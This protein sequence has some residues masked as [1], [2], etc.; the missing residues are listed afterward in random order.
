L[1]IFLL[2]GHLRPAKYDFYIPKIQ[3]YTPSALRSFG[4]ISS[5]SAFCSSLAI[6]SSVVFIYQATNDA[7]NVRPVSER[8]STFPK[9][10]ILSVQIQGYIAQLFS[11]E[12]LIGKSLLLYNNTCYYGS[13]PLPYSARL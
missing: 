7:I 10:T 3:I 13:I 4:R 5:N 11:I 8:I 9:M 1:T 6:S 12:K 2:F